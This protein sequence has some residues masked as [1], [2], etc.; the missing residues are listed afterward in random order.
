MPRKISAKTLSGLLGSYLTRFPDEMAETAAQSSPE[1]ASELLALLA[2]RD[3][4]ALLRLVEPRVGETWLRACEA[5]TLRRLIRKAAPDGPEL[6]AD[7]SDG[8][9]QRMAITML[10]PD[11]SAD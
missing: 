1:Q 8:E 4:W 11:D 7:I 6:A 2:P 9:L 10:S 5:D 3:S